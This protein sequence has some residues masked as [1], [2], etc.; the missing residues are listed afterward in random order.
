MSTRGRAN[1]I[2]AALEGR[3]EYGG[4][5]LPEAVG[6]CLSCKACGKECPSNVDMSLLKAE[7][8]HARHR[9][10]GT[11]LLE[12]FISRFDLLGRMGTTAPRLI[13]GMLKTRP[14]R[15]VIEKAMGLASD[16]PLPEYARERFEKWFDRRNKGKST[17]GAVYLWNDCTTR[18]FEPEI[19]RAA[20]RV[21]EAAGY[22]VRL[23]NTGV[24]CGRPAFSVGR[25]D[26][27]RRFGEKNVRY[28]AGQQD[29]APIIFLEP[30][31]HSMYAGDYE[32]L[33]I[34]DARNVAARCVLF[35]QF[36]DDLLRKEP[37]ALQFAPRPGSRVAVHAHC[38]AKALT[39]T[40]VVADIARRV[41]G[42]EAWMLDTGCCGMAGSFGALRDKYA[43]SV[44]VARPLVDCVNKLPGGTALISSGTSC[45][46][47]IGHLTNAKPVHFAQ[48]LESALSNMPV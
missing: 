2:R 48:W 35:E 1:I 34:A 24:C 46:Q 6:N 5:A 26:V 17:R 7:L 41:P 43:L 20:V 21:L 22:E 13:N 11:G 28:F 44:A 38:H 8:L 31:C 16:R 30:S 45:R 4:D 42:V 36:I 15:V 10:R 40:N 3:L 18:F 25:L 32:E 14:A 12:R 9:E 39:E 37:D 29:D 19:G 47:Q 33:R 23:A 27:A